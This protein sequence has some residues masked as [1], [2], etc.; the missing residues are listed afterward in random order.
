MKVGITRVVL[1]SLLRPETIARA[2]FQIQ[3]NHKEQRWSN[4]G[5]VKFA[6]SIG[7]SADQPMQSTK[8]IN[9]SRMRMENSTSQSLNTNTSAMKG[10]GG[11]LGGFGKKPKASQ[12]ETSDS[13]LMTTTVEVTSFARSALDSNLFDIS[14]RYGKCRQTLVI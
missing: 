3:R 7:D 8:Y 6:G 11:I 1:T 5:L 4:V 9:G 10:L 2:G 14:Q 12:Q 13:S